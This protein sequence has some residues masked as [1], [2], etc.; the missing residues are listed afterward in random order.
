LAWIEPSGSPH[1]T[2]QFAYWLKLQGSKVDCKPKPQGYRCLTSRQIDV[3]Q[4]AIMNGAGRAAPGA[5]S[6]YLS[7]QAQAETQ[8]RGVWAR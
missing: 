1:L 5:P 8:R 6:E 3:A 2:R 7:A 4:A